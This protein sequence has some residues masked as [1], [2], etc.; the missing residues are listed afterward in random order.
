M[1][2][3]SESGVYKESAHDRC[4]RS[5][6]QL[7]MYRCTAPLRSGAWSDQYTCAKAALSTSTRTPTLIC[8]SCL[9]E[10]A[11]SM[12]KTMIKAGGCSNKTVPLHIRVPDAN[13]ISRDKNA[14]AGGQRISCLAHHRIYRRL[15]ACGRY[16]KISAH[17]ECT[18]MPRAELVS[19]IDAWFRIDH[20]AVCRRALRGMP[21][22]DFWPSIE[23]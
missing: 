8:H 15:K 22:L 10:S 11:R 4:G 5:T 19:A 20:T 13:S 12:P 18:G 23:R 2:G 1:L 21:M 14:F 7:T 17:P 6:D 3:M 9:T 16:S